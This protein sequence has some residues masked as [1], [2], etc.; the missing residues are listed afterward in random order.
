MRTAVKSPLTKPSALTRL[1]NLL[2]KNIVVK[3]LLWVIALLLGLLIIAAL[4]IEFFIFPNINQYKNDIAEQASLIAKQKVSIGQ[5]QAGW[6]GLNPNIMM[7]NIILFDAENRPALA[8]NQAEAAL[9]WLSIPMLEPHFAAIDIKAPSLNIRRTINSEIF[10][11]G[12]SLSGP[13]KPALSNWLLR[14]NAIHITDAN[15][16]WLDEL[17]SAPPLSLNKLN[18]SLIT[19]AWK[20]ILKNHQLNISATPSVGTLHPITL[21]ANLYGNDISQLQQWHGTVEIQQNALEIAAFKPW[22]DYLIDVT[23]GILN[24]KTKIQFAQGSLRTIQTEVQLKQLVMPLQANAAPTHFNSVAADVLWENLNTQKLP[25]LSL[26][27]NSPNFKVSTSNV[28]ITANQTAL[29]RDL[30]ASYTQIGNAKST[31]GSTLGLQSQAAAITLDY[32]NIDAISPYLLQLPLPDNFLQTLQSASATGKLKA[33]SASWEASNQKTT[34]YKIATDFENLGVNANSIAAEGNATTVETNIGLPIGFSGLSG[35]IEADQEGGK[36]KL[37]TTQ[38]ALDFKHILRYPI[39]SN[40]LNGTVKWRI[41]PLEEANNAPQIRITASDF[42]IKN[43]HLSGQVSVVYEIHPLKSHAID[44]TATFD[45]GDAKYAPFY[46]P[47]SLNADTL[48]WLDTSIKAGELSDIKLVLKGNLKDFPFV[49]AAHALDP[50]LGVF[51]VTA[52]MQ[53]GLLEYGSDWPHITDLNTSLLFEGTRMELNATGG[54]ISGNRILKSKT[55]IAQLDAD[56]PILNIVSEAQGPVVEGIKF[57]NNSPVASITQGFTNNLKTSGEGHLD[58]SLRIPL[59]NVEQANYKGAYRITNGSMQSP[60]VPSITNINGTLSFNENSLTANNVKAQFYGTPLAFNIGTDKDKTI[61]VSAKG[62][63]NNNAISQLIG[64][65][66][67]YITGSTAWVANIA[68]QNQL[69]N[70]VIRSDLLGLSSTLPAPFNKLA[71]ERASLR[72][73]QKQLNDTEVTQVFYNNILNASVGRKLQNNSLQLQYGNIALGNT[74]QKGVEAAAN[75]AGLSG[76]SI[77]GALNTLN[78]DAWLEVVNAM[79]GNTNSTNALGT[80]PL[81]KLDLQ[82]ADL[83]VFDKHIHQLK[84]RNATN[85]ANLA[86]AAGLLA[87]SGLQ[88]NIDSQEIKGDV[89]WLSKSGIQ[90]TSQANGKLIARLTHL[91]IPAEKT[92]QTAPSGNTAVKD[93]K[94]LKQDYPALD[95]TAGNFELDNKKLGALTLAAYPQNDN[96]VIQKLKL[97]NT[98]SVLNIDGEWN[99]WVRNP[100]TRLN[101]DL[102]VN[103]LGKT[104]HRFGHPD[105]IKDGE[106][107][108]SGQLNWAGSPHEFNTRGLNGNLRFDIRKGQ[109]LKVQPGVGRLFGLVSLQSLPRRL[110]L[111]FRDLF[112]SGFAFDTI[113]ADVK[114]S[115]GLISSDNF[116]MAGPAADVQIKGEANMVNE[117]QNMRVKVNPRISDSVSLA[118]LAGGPLVGAIAFLAQKILK[119]PLNKIA[120]TEYI[121][122]GTWDNPVEL[123][124][125]DAQNTE[126]P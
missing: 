4:V 126:Q 122:G 59:Q 61:R 100:N 74:L 58:L 13:S 94:Q 23:S 118:A 42:K 82:I 117:T 1:A 85:V 56:E 20:K 83:T 45:Q 60:S 44:L 109:I 47:T 78:A 86:N 104:I 10:V 46:Y 112:S 34:R 7:E 73:Q 33:L 114:V 48:H 52:N 54:L 26:I 2:F 99:N 91:S 8:L 12:I 27:L 81:K 76:L 84:I 5:I 21:Q 119:D 80:L 31:S 92:T 57:V 121:I 65:A 105:T 64:K 63:L 68:V 103:D 39:L 97:T 90:N 15:I 72:I 70:I 24:A 89:Q 41:D 28:F 18:I 22:I 35:S 40:Q 6:R 116:V 43:A 66:N 67:Q 51:R 53:K 120:S 110:S 30:S 3:V 95:I 16:V 17:R 38:A 113:K 79:T 37:N 9:S 49:N 98:D 115:Q 11:A 101:I 96:W 55:T 106:G 50:K 75:N 102:T 69:V 87:T 93:F 77:N 123:K 62:R 25:T 36:L 32:A 29:L 108:L 71:S 19:P 124:G 14:Q 111:D 125:S 88:A 107:H